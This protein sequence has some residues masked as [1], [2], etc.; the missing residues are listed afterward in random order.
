MVE[1]PLHDRGFGN[2]GGAWRGVGRGGMKEVWSERRGVCK[3]LGEGW[4]CG[5]SFGLACKT[6]GRS[7][8]SR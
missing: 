8:G 6:N 1:G 7:G 4:G 2:R 3:G 5:V